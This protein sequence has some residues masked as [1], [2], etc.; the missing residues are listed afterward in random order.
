MATYKSEILIGGESVWDT[1]TSVDKQTVQ[2]DVS[3]FTGRKDLKF[4]MTKTGG[5]TPVPPVPVD[6]DACWW[7]FYTRAIQNDGISTQGEYD[8]DLNLTTGDF[9]LLM[10]V[11]EIDTPYKNNGSHGLLGKFKQGLGTN[12]GYEVIYDGSSAGF[13]PGKIDFYI[14]QQ[15]GGS[16]FLTSANN[17]MSIGRKVLIACTYERKL[18]DWTNIATIVTFD[19]VNGKLVVSRND[20]P[21]PGNNTYNLDMGWSHIHGT[22]AD[23][24]MYWCG[25]Y[26]GLLMT[27][28][29]VEDIW[30]E[31]KHP[32]DDFNPVL[33]NYFCQNV[34][35]IYIS[36]VGN[37]LNAPYTFDVLGTPVKGP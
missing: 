8:P 17:I 6:V 26:D 5:D 1:T 30:N 32:I 11:E 35:A 16:R 9:T 28:Q 14:G 27:E 10:L 19:A 23:V 15:T 18:I 34:G 36:D 2:L 7:E 31:T 13:T 24:K 22:G 33:F 21:W 4:K 29:N 20:M 25:I 12:G 37:G 3:R